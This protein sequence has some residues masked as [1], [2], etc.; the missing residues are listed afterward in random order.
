M[1][2]SS[3]E[4]VDG[5]IEVVWLNAHHVVKRL[6]YSGDM[7]VLMSSNTKHN[8]IYVHPGEVTQ[9]TL[10][11]TRGAFLSEVAG[12]SASVEV[13]AGGLW[14]VTGSRLLFHLRR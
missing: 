11:V 12:E 5:K 9:V 7:I 14:A 3:R 4:V 8:P 10:D 13:M 1:V 6:H 2:D